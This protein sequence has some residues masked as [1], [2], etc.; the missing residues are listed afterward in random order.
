MSDGWYASTCPRHA[1]ALGSRGP[2]PKGR[3]EAP[4]PVQ[5]PEWSLDQ[6]WAVSLAGAAPTL[7]RYKDDC[8]ADDAFPAL[9]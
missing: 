6:A 1:E 4:G 8:F 5:A 7:A 2:P 9:K 3:G